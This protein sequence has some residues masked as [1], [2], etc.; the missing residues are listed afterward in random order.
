MKTYSTIKTETVETIEYGNVLNSHLVT[1]FG[2]E[3]TYN[4]L[5]IYAQNHTNTTFLKVEKTISDESHSI[6]V[7]FDS[8]IVLQKVY[9][10]YHCITMLNELNEYDD[11]LIREKERDREEYGCYYDLTCGELEESVVL[12]SVDIIDAEP[13]KKRIIKKKIN[14][15]Q[16]V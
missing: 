16:S 5:Q 9:A 2:D 3:M 15:S 8:Q 4:E 11:Y 10:C 1:I 12:E 6:R 13:V 7:W 14:D